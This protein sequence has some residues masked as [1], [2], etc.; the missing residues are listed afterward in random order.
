[1]ATG[2]F[3]H[4]A[5]LLTSGEVL[6]AGGS[7]GGGR[8]INRAELYDP[9]TD[10]WS[11]AAS[12]A[13][14][15]YDHTA[16]LL[17]SGEVLVTGGNTCGGPSDSAE[18]YDATAM[19]TAGC[20]AAP[21]ATCFIAAQNLVVLKDKTHPAKRKFLWKWRHGVTPVMQ[22]DFGY[23]GQSTYKLCV[24]DQTGTLPVFKMGFTLGPDEL[25]SETGR[26]R[27]LGSIG[28]RYTNRAG[29]EDGV[30]KLSLEG[31]AAAEPK[32]IMKGG[33]TFLPVP[34]PISGTAFFAQDPA[35]IVQ[36]Y[37]SSPMN[38]WSSTFD[39]SSTKANSGTQ[40]K[41]VTP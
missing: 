22:G 4:T 18:L 11:A 39:A 15:R 28:W 6:V 41:A 12:M 32:I 31:G 35:V 8:A 23:P 30:T 21:A 19:F 2:R 1:M 5:T 34:I 38:C 3:D 16:T 40:F 36:L 7:T 29:N 20:P 13:T 25:C 33:G 37:S 9:A 14:G 17:A 24:Y 26:W 10:T 27:A